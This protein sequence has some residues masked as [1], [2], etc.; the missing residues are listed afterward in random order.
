MADPPEHRRATCPGCGKRVRYLAKME[1]ESVKCRSCDTA[2]TL[3]QALQDPG[4]SAPGATRRIA[5]AIE[6]S[7]EIQPKDPQ[8]MICPH[9]GRRN[10]FDG[11]DRGTEVP[12]GECGIAITLNEK[13]LPATLAS[14]VFELRE[15]RRLNLRR[16]LMRRISGVVL[17]AGALLIGWMLHQDALHNGSISA[18][19]LGDPQLHVVISQAPTSAVAAGLFWL[20]LA[21]IVSG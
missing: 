20:G 16:A 19:G 7:L 11:A 1:G 15:A 17:I 3:T 5:K 9:C 21:R 6:K 18:F 4:K 2:M 12:C 13:A 8:D 10:V 14:V